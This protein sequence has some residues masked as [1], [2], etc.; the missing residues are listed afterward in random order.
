MGVGRTM[1]AAAVLAA[2]AC[3]GS[4][5]GPAGP[6]T[7]MSVGLD[8]SPVATTAV[9]SST[10]SVG[11][12]DRSPPRLQD[13]LPE[14]Q[15]RIVADGEVSFAEYEEAVLATV[16]CL[17]ARGVE[18]IGPYLESEAGRYGRP[19]FTVGP[20]DPS[21][22]YLWSLTSPTEEGIE[23]AERQNAACRA[24]YLDAVEV[25]YT[26]LNEPS[27][28]E[29]ADWYR[30]LEACLKANGVEVPAGDRS[31]LSSF[32]VEHRDLGCPDAAADR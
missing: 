31:T 30:R 19:V 20:R 27:E 14:F 28:E 25:L 2:T 18:V 7:A 22:F 6:T 17:R 24:E 23:D 9:V 10:T 15:A 32:A 3:S 12:P 11:V 13:D 21:R 8:G 1:A 4:P 29:W 16:R 5:A 26:W